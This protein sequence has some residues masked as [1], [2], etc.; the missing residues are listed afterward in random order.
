MRAAINGTELFYDIV[1]RTSP[2]PPVVIMHGPGFDHTFLRPWLDPLAGE[3]QVIFFDMR[4]CGRSSRSESTVVPIIDTLV[5]DIDALRSHLGSDQIVLHGHSFSGLTALSYALKHANHL[6]GLILD[7]TAPHFN[8]PDVMM[9]NLTARGSHEQI[10]AMVEVFKAQ[11]ASDEAFQRGWNL[12]MPIYFHRYDPMIGARVS[13]HMQFS[14]AVLNQFGAQLPSMNFI[15][16]LPDI[17]VPTLVLAGRD[18]WICPPAESAERLHAGLP[19]SNLVVFEES[20][21]FPFIEEQDTYLRT[22]EDWLQ[23]LS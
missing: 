23:T 19:N 16:Q 9:S 17:S 8:Y 2:R 7:C 21:H 10:Q 6:M 22:V 4:G 3:R 5:D 20:G 13:A 14:V 1:G 15:T 12:V 18:D 11:V